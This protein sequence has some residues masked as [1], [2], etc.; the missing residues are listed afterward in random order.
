MSEEAFPPASGGPE[1]GRQSAADG[2]FFAPK[3]RRRDTV[4][5]SH[6]EVEN[7]VEAFWRLCALHPRLIDEAEAAHEESLTAE[8]RDARAMRRRKRIRAKAEAAMAEFERLPEIERYDPQKQGDLD[9][10][11]EENL[12]IRER[13]RDDRRV[14]RML[15]R[16][17]SGSSAHDDRDKNE[18]LDHDEYERFYARLVHLV[19]PDD[20]MTE[21]E[22]AEAMEDD[23]KSDSEGHAQVT[24]DEFVASVF[25]L[26]DNWTNS[27]DADEY[28]EFLKLGYDRVYRGGKRERH[29]QLQRLLSRPVSTR[30]G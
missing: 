8:E 1:P 2:R 21:L 26:A 20:E 17:W 19:D 29:S 28:V 3:T 4:Y 30:F 5:A 16:W 7:S 18:A 14:C 13:L 23:F 27:T 15:E 22:I 9:M 24:K 11:S 6:V 10:Y 12:A 25:E